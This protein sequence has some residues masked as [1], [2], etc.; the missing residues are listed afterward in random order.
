MHKGG[1]KIKQW[2]TSDVRNGLENLVNVKVVERD[3]DKRNIEKVLGIAWNKCSDTLTFNTKL[4]FSIGKRSS[5]FASHELLQESIPKVLTRRMILAQVN[6]MYDP[7]GLISPFVVRA[8][9][10]MRK[11][12]V[13]E[14]ILGWD[15]PLPDSLKEDWTKYFKEV[16]MLREIAFPRAVKS[17]DAMGHPE[18]VI[19][20]NGSMEAYGTV[21]YVRW[22]LK[23]EMRIL[24]SKTRV[25]PLK[26]VSIVRL[27]LSGAIISKRLRVFLLK[28]MRYKFKSIFH[29]IDSEIVQAMISKES[30]GFNTYVANWISGIQAKTVS[31]DWF[32]VSDKLNISDWLARGK[33]PNNLDKKTMWQIGPEFLSRKFEEWPV[34]QKIGLKELPERIQIVTVQTARTQITDSLVKRI[35]ITCFSKFKLLI[36]TLLEF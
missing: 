19:L 8:K 36:N 22:E 6:R 34:T 4:D 10:M 29:I 17:K 21:S 3:T 23:N 9:I 13:S 33:C 30:Y 2:N 16:P 11:L 1:F 24:A 7:L 25:A 27:E 31:S 20:S 12:W 15:D 35:D 18:L 26:M 14:P 28:E 5:F 32:L